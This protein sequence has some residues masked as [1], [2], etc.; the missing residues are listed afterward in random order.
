MGPK[1][2]PTLGPNHLTKRIRLTGV[3]VIGVDEHRWAPRRLSAAGFV[4]LII[5]L[6]LNQRVR[7]SKP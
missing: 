3:R 4:T 2:V 5:D 6:T 1:F 7:G